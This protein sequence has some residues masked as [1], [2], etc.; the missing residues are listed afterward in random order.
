[1]VVIVT[2]GGDETHSPQ[3]GSTVGLGLR[4]FRFTANEALNVAY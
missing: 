3:S 4:D 1:M 2:L